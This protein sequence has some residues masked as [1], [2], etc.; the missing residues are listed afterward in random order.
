MGKTGSAAST[1]C[2]GA[3]A[4][5]PHSLASEGQLRGGGHMPPLHIAY[6][7]RNA[8]GALIRVASET[9]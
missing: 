8:V 3:L 5:A 4:D 7:T 1:S 2:R 9:L 6:D